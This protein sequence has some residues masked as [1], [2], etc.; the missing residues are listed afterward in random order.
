MLTSTNAPA[1]PS[2]KSTVSVALP[3]PR[4]ALASPYAAVTEIENPYAVASSR[5]AVRT[6]QPYACS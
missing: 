2:A 5:R 3:G 4:S 1:A 6:P